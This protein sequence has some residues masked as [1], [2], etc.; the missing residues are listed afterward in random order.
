MT[1]MN[2]SETTNYK[3]VLQIVHSWSPAAQLAF[4]QDVLKS[5]A[6]ELIPPRSQRNTLEQA[7][8]L[9]ATD[10]PAPSDAE[11]AQLLAERRLEKYG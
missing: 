4:V 11:V 10:H 2:I 5:L 7:L 9:L 3:T 1:I 8:G 6:V